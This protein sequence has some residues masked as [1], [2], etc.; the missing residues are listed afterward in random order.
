MS[1]NDYVIA[2][3]TAANVRADLNLALAALASQSSGATAPSTT[4]A[5][6]I[7]YD[8]AN[9]TLKMRSEADDAWITLGTLDQSL[10]TFS[11][12]ESPAFTG[13][14]TAP[15]AADGTDTTQIATTAFVKSNSKV[16]QVQRAQYSSVVSGSSTMP[17]DNTIP[18]ITEG[19]AFM[20]LAITPTN[21]S[22]LLQIDVVFFASHSNN[23]EVAYAIF[24]DSTANALAAVA[25]VGTSGKP[26]VVTFSHQ[27]VAGTT[28]ATTLKVRAGPDSATHVIYLNG[29]SVGGGLF[30]GVAA[31]SIT[32]TEIAV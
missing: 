22:N 29:T 7:W 26:S 6:M 15:T 13:I 24:Q 4:Y 32:I 18:Q 19:S 9:D 5:N 25:E 28:S 16:V 20:E 10:N 23:R 1:Q 3:D 21:A 14:P 2:N 27:M 17:V 30:G 8:T 31:S 11:L 12:P